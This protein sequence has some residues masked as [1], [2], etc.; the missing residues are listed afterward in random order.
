M[1]AKRTNADFITEAKAIHG[2]KY[3]YDLV[4]YVN[5]HT[6]V[7]IQCNKCSKSFALTPTLHLNRKAGC[8]VCSPR[9]S[10][11]KITKEVFLE[12]ANK[13]HNSN[14]T[15][16]DLDF[17][18]AR[19]KVKWKCNTCGNIHSQIVY[20]HLNGAG[21]IVCHTKSKLKSDVSSDTSNQVVNT[22]DLSFHINS[23]Y[24]HLK[25]IENLKK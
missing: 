17:K 20:S 5:N 18:D 16:L 10:N 14:F 7:E 12:R 4:N 13:V 9:R 21:C 22:N 2:D 6:P 15:Y 11:V 25:Q 3:N 8:P 1:T 19:D 23:I 24:Y